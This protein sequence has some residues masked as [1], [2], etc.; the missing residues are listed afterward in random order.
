MPGQAG[1]RTV[2]IARQ[3]QARAV[4]I[5]LRRGGGTGFGRTLETLLT[6]R[7]CRIIIESVPE[8][9]PDDKP[10]EALAGGR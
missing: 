7:P 3:M 8:T 5:P 10:R 2:D 1:R 4:V 6:E 9:K